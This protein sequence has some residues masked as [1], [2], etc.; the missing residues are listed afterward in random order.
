VWNARFGADPALVGRE[1]RLQGVSHTV[2]GILPAGFRFVEA[3]EYTDFF[4]PLRLEADPRDQGHN[5]AVLGRLSRGVT[6]DLAEQ[7]LAA[8]TARFQAEHP[9]ISSHPDEGM[10]LLGYRDLY[11]ADL[12]RTLW[13][14]LGAVAFVLLIA[15][16]NVASLLLARAPAGSTRSRSGPRWAPGAPASYGSS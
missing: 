9:E 5:Y 15:C 2:I 11:V 14:L 6:R 10:M 12:A 13:I 7:D 3:P 8:V 16:A 4:L 1:V